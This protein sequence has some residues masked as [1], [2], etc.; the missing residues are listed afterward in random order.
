[1][2]KI[3][4][5]IAIVAI[6]LSATTLTHNIEAKKKRCEKYE[7]GSKSCIGDKVKYWDSK[8]KMHTCKVVTFKGKDKCNL[9]KSVDQGQHWRD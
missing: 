7:D 9:P 1:M 8:G 6:L 2:H 4:F 3:V 5:V